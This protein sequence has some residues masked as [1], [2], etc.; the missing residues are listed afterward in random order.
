MEG[1]HVSKS[2]GTSMCELARLAGRKNNGFNPY[3]N[4]KVG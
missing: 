3:A 4:C 2:G 1:L